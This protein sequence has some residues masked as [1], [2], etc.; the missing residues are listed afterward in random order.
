MTVEIFL[1][2]EELR[3]LCFFN[4]LQLKKIHFVSSPSINFMRNKKIS[5]VLF[6]IH[7]QKPIPQQDSQ[8]PGH[9]GDSNWYCHHH[10]PGNS[11]RWFKGIHPKHAKIWWIGLQSPKPTP[12]VWD[13]VKSMNAG[14]R[15]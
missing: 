13:P 9:S 5:D 11:N 1:E 12:R 6:N 7:P 14:W 3:F 15:I 10:S 8:C 2:I 4:F